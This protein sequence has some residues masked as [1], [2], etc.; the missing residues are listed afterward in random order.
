M[1]LIHRLNVL[2]VLLA[3]ATLLPATA[4][5]IAPSAP[6][7]NIV[8]A[9]I[10][11]DERSMMIVPVSING[12]GPYDFML[13]TGA[14]KTIVDQKLAEELHLSKVGERTVVGVLA[15]AK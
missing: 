9:K 7:P 6:A 1:S 4:Q 10:R 12:S 3:S 2:F 5:I 13:D 14:A 11:L 8:T 15:S